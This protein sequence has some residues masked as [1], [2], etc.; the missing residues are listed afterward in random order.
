MDIFVGEKTEKLMEPIEIRTR[1][2]SQP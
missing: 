1:D 2:L